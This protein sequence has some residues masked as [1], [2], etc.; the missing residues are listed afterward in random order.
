MCEKSLGL[1]EG[2]GGWWLVF[3]CKAVARISQSRPKDSTLLQTLQALQAKHFLQACRKL[4][5]GTSQEVSVR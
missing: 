2:K 4:S 5:I 3:E 1:G